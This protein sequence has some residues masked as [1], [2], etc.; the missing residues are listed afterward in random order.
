[1]E[2]WREGESLKVNT[3]GAVISDGGHLIPKSKLEAASSDYCLMPGCR[4]TPRPTLKNITEQS[5]VTRRQPE[6]K[7][8]LLLLLK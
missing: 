1:M 3:M 4:S 7:L 6:R 5:A 2:D 8:L